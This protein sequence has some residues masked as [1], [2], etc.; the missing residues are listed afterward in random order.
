MTEPEKSKK[1]PTK[2]IWEMTPKERLD[3]MSTW[4]LLFDEI[5]FN[6]WKEAMRLESGRNPREYIR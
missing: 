6:R 4:T 1:K 3:E 5:H 2:T